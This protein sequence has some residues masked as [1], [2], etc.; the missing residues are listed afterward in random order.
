M[1]AS[2][3]SSTFCR[4]PRNESQFASPKASNNATLEDE[5][6]VLAGDLDAEVYCL[7]WPSACYLDRQGV[8]AV[9]AR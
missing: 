3:P 1:Q 4:S 7:R 2:S 5:I 9:V 8:I 6:V